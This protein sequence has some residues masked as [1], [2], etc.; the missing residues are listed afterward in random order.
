[1]SYKLLKVVKG[2][3]KKLTALITKLQNNNEKCFVKN[4]RVKFHLKTGDNSGILKQEYPWEH[5]TRELYCAEVS[6]DTC[7]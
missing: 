7:N 5:G 3:S 1:M 6:L 4:K 2:I